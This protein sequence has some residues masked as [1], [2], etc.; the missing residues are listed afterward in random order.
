MNKILLSTEILYLSQWI[1]KT[2]LEKLYKQKHSF[3]EMA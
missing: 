2:E 1:Y 3:S